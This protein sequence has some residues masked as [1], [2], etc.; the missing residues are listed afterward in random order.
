M[1]PILTRILESLA[2]MIVCGGTASVVGIIA[3]YTISKT[4]HGAVFSY[5]LAI[6]FG[7]FFGI[8][9]FVRTIRQQ[10]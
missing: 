8:F 7:I 10:W 9:G 4:V 6:I 5:R 2:I 1:P 3:S